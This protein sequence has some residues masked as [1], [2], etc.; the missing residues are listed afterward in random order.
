MLFGIIIVAAILAGLVQLPGIVGAFLVG[1]ALN[2]SAQ[3]KPAKEKLGFFGNTLFIPAFFLVTGFLIDPAVFIRSLI[4]NFALAVSI[5]LALLIGKFL[6]AEIAGRSFIYPV[7]ARRTMWSLTLPQVAATLAATI[8]GFNTFDP[9]GVR[10]ID[11]RILNAVFVLM[12]VTSILG[13][14][15]TQYYTPLMLQSY[16]ARD[17]SR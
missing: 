8:V 13:P 12:L 17:V 4:D 6:A 9:A 15:L 7:P 10:L 14:V 2:E 5:I 3:N 16:R 1:L 11:E